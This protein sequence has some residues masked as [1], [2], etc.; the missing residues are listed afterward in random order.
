MLHYVPQCQGPLVGP[1]TTI[2]WIQ[3][4]Q[5]FVCVHASRKNIN[6]KKENIL[7]DE[8]KRN[9]VHHL[10]KHNGQKEQCHQA[11]PIFRKIS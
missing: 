9:I 10:S 4:M 6:H 11:K 8:I 7:P 1:T 3:Q 2:I 5:V